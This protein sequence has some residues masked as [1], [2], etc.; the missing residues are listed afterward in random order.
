LSKHILISSK[1]SFYQEN[2]LNVTE[3]IFLY[4]AL[5]FHQKKSWSKIH[6]LKISWEE[7]SWCKISWDK[8]HGIDDHGSVSVKQTM[9]L[10]RDISLSTCKFTTKFI[11]NFD[12]KKTRFTAGA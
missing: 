9:E 10:P 6:G 11:V 3:Q 4:G 2:A 7:F 8:N 1:Y 12:K 5:K